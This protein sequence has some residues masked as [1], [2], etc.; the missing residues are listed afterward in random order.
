MTTPWANGVAGAQKN[1]DW[2][3]NIDRTPNMANYGDL[4]FLQ[5]GR[6]KDSDWSLAENLSMYNPDW[7]DGTL[8]VRKI[9][10]I[11]INNFDVV[12][13]LSG[14]TA[15]K[16][17]ILDDYLMNGGRL[18]ME[19]GDWTTMDGTD[20]YNHLGLAATQASG[21]VSS[22]MG[23]EPAT[24]GVELTY[25]GTIM[26]KFT[27]NSE[28]FPALIAD[29]GDV[30]AV[31]SVDIDTQD[32]DNSYRAVS[33]AVKY[34]RMSEMT[35]SAP[36]ELTGMLVDYFLL[37][38]DDVNHQ[39]VIE[40]KDPIADPEI[41]LY[42]ARPTLLWQNQDVDVW[43][44]VAGTMQYT[45]YISTNANDVANMHPDAMSSV[46][47]Q[48]TPTATMVDALDAPV[49]GIYHWGIFAEDKYGK[50]TYEYGGV[51]KYDSEVPSVNSLTAGNMETNVWDDPLPIGI[52][53]VFGPGYMNSQGETVGRPDIFA[54]DLSDN[55]GLKFSNNHNEAH[56]LFADEYLPP[57]TAFSVQVHYFYGGQFEDDLP[58][59]NLYVDELGTD[60]DLEALT[61]EPEVV[62]YMIPDAPI[63]DGQYH[64]YILAAD[65]VR[66]GSFM[67]WTF[68]V[69][70]TAPEQPMDIM[71]DPETYIDQ[72]DE[73]FLKAG[74][75]YTL[76]C[77]APSSADDG[78]MNR[79]EFQQAVANFP[80]AT[81]ETIG[82]DYD[83]TDNTYSVLW[84]PDT[85]HF[86]VRAIAYDYVENFIIS[87]VFSSFHVDGIGPEAPLTVQADLDLTHTP[88][89]TV[90]GYVFDT[91][92][93]GQTSGVAYVVI[94]HYDSASGM[95]ELVTDDQGE[96][97]QVPVID[98]SFEATVDLESITGATGDLA[99]AFYT[100]AIDNV[101][102]E[103]EMSEM[104]TWVDTGRQ[105]SL[106]VISPSSI[107]DVPMGIDVDDTDDSL[108]E[109][110][111]IKV[112]FLSTEQDF[113]NYM[114][115]IRAEK[116]RTSSDA[117]GIGLPQGTKFL[118]NY[119]NVE[120]PPEFTNFEAQVT[121]EFHISARS[122]LGTRTSEILDN[123]RLVAKHSGED[124]FEVLDIIG[125]QPQVVDEDKGIYRVQ[126]RVN[127][128]SDFAVIV[129]Q[130]DVTVSDII[131]GASPAIAG[132]EMSI[133]VTV[134]NGGDF[135]KDAE[136]VKVKVFAIDPDGNQ[137]FIDELDYGTI[138]AEIDY[139]PSDPA[140][141]KGEKQATLFWTTSTLLSDGEVQTFTIRAQVDPDGYVREISETNNEATKDVE[142][143]GSA[144][145]TPSFELTFMMMALGVL[146][147]S[148][149]SVYVRKRK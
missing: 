93:E 32:P 53:R 112:T 86:Y 81:W 6:V 25:T 96:V 60:S 71:V 126:A 125:G 135:P 57:A 35:R 100:Q 142:V 40:L 144:G 107:K 109:I 141:K 91:I 97:I 34:E 73:L 84:T 4:T 143:V 38:D 134:H 29:T 26:S 18:Y 67:D 43:D 118:Y 51:F 88:K 87:E 121:I 78:S 94:W 148:G 42:K 1:A 11:Y 138:D 49:A 145:S 85:E 22:L 74:E 128:F 62:F 122:Q 132:Q 123:I 45:L 95:M 7:A 113:M 98:L 8:G 76:S 137:E 133:T 64:F 117:T 120:V 111:S 139:Y 92:V 101:G 82:T 30:V 114:F 33:S 102:N 20:L 56:Q 131:L 9:D 75:T 127:R 80:G 136:N 23:A 24:E 68:E 77:W 99:Y 63:P 69:D 116:L 39:P 66:W 90:S 129:A 146:V 83:V 59:F 41:P 119:F 5:V 19:A 110:R 3:H 65:E 130:T 48:D 140:L 55:F 47:V 79:V 10:D 27:T 106:R 16:Q 124:G 17:D 70:L 105:E 147:V 28:S 37:N 54:I 108:D 21:P 46:F 115:T 36:Y 50:T 103:G 2:E 31:L 14:V 44:Q 104:A 13:A 15:S 12:F 61:G 89:A 72:F 58:N 52:T 149:M